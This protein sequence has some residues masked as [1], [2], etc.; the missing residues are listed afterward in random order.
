MPRKKRNTGL[1][2]I[3]AICPINLKVKELAIR[4]Q[5]SVIQRGM[6]KKAPVKIIFFLQ[7]ILS[8]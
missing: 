1:V 6:K 5:V 3:A 7:R 2:V 4:G 8:L